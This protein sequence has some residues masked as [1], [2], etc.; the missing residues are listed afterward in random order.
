MTVQGLPCWSI[1]PAQRPP[2]DSDGRR[3]TNMYETKNETNRSPVTSDEGT[4]LSDLTFR[5]L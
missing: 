1:W 2:V 3:Y 4:D 5:R